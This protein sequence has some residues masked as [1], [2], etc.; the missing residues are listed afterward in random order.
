MFNALFKQCLM[1]P[2]LL[3]WKHRV[4]TT[5]PPEKSLKVTNILVRIRSSALPQTRDSVLAKGSSSNGDE[6][7]E[8]AEKGESGDVRC[9]WYLHY[10]IQGQS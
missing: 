1:L 5:R 7:Q 2:H 6:E 9:S 3:H 4:L 10:V 8:I